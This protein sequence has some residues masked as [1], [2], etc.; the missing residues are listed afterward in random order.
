M[1][2][3]GFSLDGTMNVNSA[4]I[5]GS[6]IST[7]EHSLVDVSQ[8]GMCRPASLKRHRA[9]L[10]AETLVSRCRKP[11]RRIWPKMVPSAGELLHS[12]LPRQCRV[13]QESGEPTTA[14]L[15][16]LLS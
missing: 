14:R 13:R 7:M 15:N 11:D 10:R 2:T 12:K 3:C 16:P 6:G 5:D 9:R 4:L 1:S 8:T